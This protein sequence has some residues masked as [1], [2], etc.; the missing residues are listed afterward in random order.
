VTSS[1]G[2]RDDEAA[3]R[4]ALAVKRLRARMR[5]EAPS[6]GGWTTSQLS[7]LSRIIE[8]APVTA[9]AIAQAEHVRPQSIASI[10]ST[11][12]AA[13]LVTA[14]ADPADGRKLL[15][16]PTDEGR[17]LVATVSSSR[18]QW[19]AHAIEAVVG[20]E[21]RAALLTTIEMLDR[22]AECDLREPAGTVVP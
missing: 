13:G 1:P 22:L 21:D 19:L 5:A 12:R 4:L 17:A 15:L 9:A 7:T 8:R 6:A 2:L 11:L 18:R 14:A 3:V 16:S 10:I 20:P